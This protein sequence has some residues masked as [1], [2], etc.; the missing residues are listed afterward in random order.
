MR[1]SLHCLLLAGSASLTA[2]S[3][4]PLNPEAEAVM[5]LPPERV[6][7][8]QRLGQT[9]VSGL[10][11]LGAIPRRPEIVDEEF[12][13]IA[14]NTAAQM[15]GD[16]IAPLGERVEGQQTFGIYRCL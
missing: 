8:C 13:T 10:Q 9:R 7:H 1:K 4:V 6:A 5:V 2:C 15:G 12:A 11:N 16:T 14:R 3:W